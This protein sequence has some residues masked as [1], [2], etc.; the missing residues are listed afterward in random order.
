MIGTGG[1]SDMRG[2]SLA[3][4]LF[5]GTWPW[6]GEDRRHDEGRMRAGAATDSRAKRREERRLESSEISSEGKSWRALE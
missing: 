6:T 1:R 4:T 5:E 2:F 3:G